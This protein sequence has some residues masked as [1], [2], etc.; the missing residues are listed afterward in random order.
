MK[1][2]IT[3]SEL[4]EMCVWDDYSYYCLD[5]KVDPLALLEANEEFTIEQNDALVCGIL[6]II[7]NNNIPHKF[8]EYV[9]HFL[10]V[11]SSKVEKSFMIRKSIL[12]SHIE[13]F[14]KKFPPE[15]KP[16]IIYKKP[17]ESALRYAAEVFNNIDNLKVT[18]VTDNMGTHEFILSS[19]V[20]K[21]LNRHTQV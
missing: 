19:A 4:V 5:K 12:L 20:K 18:K 17:I 15:F 14:S 11:R 9:G 16:S 13:K 1:L 10:S 6:K 2:T 7:E 3:P 8:N 21:Q